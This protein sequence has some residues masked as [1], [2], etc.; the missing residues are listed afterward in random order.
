M[1]KCM[2]IGIVGAGA[3]AG[4]HAAAADVLKQT[5]L[6]AVC[7]LSSDA[8]HRI[9]DPSAVPI[10]ADYHEMYTSGLVDAVIVNTPH[11]LHL[12]MVLDAAEAG[13]DVLVEKPMAT[14]VESCDT[15]MQACA[16][17]GVALVVGQIQHY[18]PD[19]LAAAEAISSGTLGRPLLI[20]DYRTTDYRPGTRPS[21]FFSESMA[22]GGA[23]MNIGGHCLDRSLWL[24]GANALSVRAS[25]RRRFGSPVETDGMLQVELANG[26][27]ASITVVSDTPE[28]TDE[29]VISCE[30]GVL[31]VDPRRG[32]RLRIDGTT[33]VLSEP[34]ADDIS[35]AFVRQLADFVAVTE[36]AE[37]R[38]PLTHARHIV[39]VVRAAYASAASGAVVRLETAVEKV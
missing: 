28:P 34:Q 16:R 3:V 11:A 14:T 38:V 24:G 26:V 21:W 9:A 31:I 22:G 18:L 25:I 32:T 17:S 8:A 29:M 7:D 15:M 6:S 12:P 13:L 35:G 19:K 20:R 10:F 5:S 27:T 37:A 23:L 36:G 2:R 33:R 1:K 30:K 39:E 4:Y